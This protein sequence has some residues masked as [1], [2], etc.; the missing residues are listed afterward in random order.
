[1]SA[2]RDEALASLRFHWGSAYEISVGDVAGVWRAVRLD[3]Q[4]TLIAT[5]AS[6]LHTLIVADYTAHPVKRG[7][8]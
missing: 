1:M 4:R 5:D 7:E 6:E 3:D 8:R 2:A